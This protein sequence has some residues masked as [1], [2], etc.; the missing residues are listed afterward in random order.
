MASYASGGLRRDRP[1]VPEE[2]LPG[3]VRLAAAGG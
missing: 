2:E 1:T 3:Q